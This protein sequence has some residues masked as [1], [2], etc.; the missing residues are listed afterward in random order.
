MFLR[1]KNETTFEYKPMPEFTASLGNVHYGMMDLKG[2]ELKMLFEIK[3]NSVF[4]VLFGQLISYIQLDYNRNVPRKKR[5]KNKV[6]YCGLMI[7]SDIYKKNDF[8][9]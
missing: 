9:L 7:N 1:I 5:E 3:V 2:T 8:Q 6:K 4:M